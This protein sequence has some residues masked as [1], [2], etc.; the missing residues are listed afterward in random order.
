MAIAIKVKEGLVVA[1]EAIE[2][3]IKEEVAFYQTEETI[4]LRT[5]N[6]I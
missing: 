5:F 6:K 3:I 2:A 1:V 4:L